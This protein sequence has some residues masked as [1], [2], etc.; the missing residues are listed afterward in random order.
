MDG[1]DKYGPVSSASAVANLLTGEWTTISGT[2]IVIVAGLSS[3]GYAI[4]LGTG[5][6]LTKTLGVNYGRLIGGVRINATLT[7]F[8]GI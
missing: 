8:A 1:F 4:S 3:T 6:G 2:Q 5:G 7:G